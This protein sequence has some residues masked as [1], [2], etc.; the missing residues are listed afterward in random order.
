MSS[1]PSGN[2][3]GTTS[4]YGGDKLWFEYDPERDAPPDRDFCP[5]CDLNVNACTCELGEIDG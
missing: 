2:P 4:G 1:P 5:A 3:D